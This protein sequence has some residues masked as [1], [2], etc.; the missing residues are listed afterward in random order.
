MTTIAVSGCIGI[1]V[2]APTAACKRLAT[3]VDAGAPG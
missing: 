3:R 2:A 1:S